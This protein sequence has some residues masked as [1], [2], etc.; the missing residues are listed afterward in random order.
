[1]N[2]LSTFIISLGVRLSCAL[3]TFFLLFAHII[4]LSVYFNTYRIILTGL[5][6]LL[7]IVQIILIIDEIRKFDEKERENI[8]NFEYLTHRLSELEEV[9]AKQ[10]RG[11]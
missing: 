11:L 4:I 5:I 1:M 9:V 10:N 2:K 3:I 8:L 7:L 6:L